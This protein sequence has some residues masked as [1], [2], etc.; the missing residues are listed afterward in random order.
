MY[1]LLDTAWDSYAAFCEE[2]EAADKGLQ[3]LVDNAW[4]NSIRPFLSSRHEVNKLQA[5][6]QNCTVQIGDL[7]SKL[8]SSLKEGDR[9]KEI[10]TEKCAQLKQEQTL[11]IELVSVWQWVENNYVSRGYNLPSHFQAGDKEVSPEL[12]KRFPNLFKHK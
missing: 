1:G 5:S 9:L 8:D 11:L 10:M 12:Q 6:V 4:E 7:K 3:E 2:F